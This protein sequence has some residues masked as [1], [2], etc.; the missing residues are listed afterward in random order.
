MNVRRPFPAAPAP[1]LAGVSTASLL[2]GLALAPA[3]SAAPGGRTL[4]EAELWSVTGGV[5]GGC[6]AP[7]EDCETSLPP[8][9][10]KTQC[11]GEGEQATVDPGDKEK[12]KSVLVQPGTA[13]PPPCNNIDSKVCK[14]SGTCTFDS[15]TGRCTTIIDDDT[16]VPAECAGQ[17]CS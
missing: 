12:C 15:A 17:T 13:P 7:I 11:F 6:C 3:L 10:E 9:G 1:L 8:C 16:E 4:T 2:L 14:Y 5:E